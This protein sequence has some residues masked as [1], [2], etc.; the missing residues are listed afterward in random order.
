MAYYK[1]L[2]TV[3]F[4]SRCIKK[5]NK[6]IGYSLGARDIKIM[7]FLYCKGQRSLRN[8]RSLHSWQ[9]INQRVIPKLQEHELI[10]VDGKMVKLKTN[11]II[12]LMK[13][14]KLLANSRM[15][16]INKWTETKRRQDKYW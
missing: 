12:V 8:L 5:L 13:Y 4:T 16:N 3:F 2:T 6:E 14:N 9:I 7:Y 1:H 11:G 15:D 10:E